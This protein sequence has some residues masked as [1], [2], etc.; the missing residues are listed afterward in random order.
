MFK[1][2]AAPRKKTTTNVSPRGAVFTGAKDKRGIHV[3]KACVSVVTII[4]LH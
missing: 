4:Y 2:S 1:T 3:G